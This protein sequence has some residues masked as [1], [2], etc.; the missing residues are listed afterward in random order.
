MLQE[1]SDTLLQHL[2]SVINRTYIT[3]LQSGQ[4]YCG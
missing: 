3:A 2:Y 1:F 4:L